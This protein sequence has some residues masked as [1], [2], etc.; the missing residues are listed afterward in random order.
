[1]KIEPTA[2]VI[3]GR[4]RTLVHLREWD[5]AL[6]FVEKLSSDAWLTPERLELVVQVLCEHERY[7]DALQAVRDAAAAGIPESR[8]EFLTAVILIRDRSRGHAVQAHDHMLRAVAAAPSNVSYW[9]A[10][11][12]LELNYYPELWTRDVC[13]TANRVRW[14][15]RTMMR[16]SCRHG[17]RWCWPKSYSYRGVWPTPMHTSGKR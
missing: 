15:L 12:H 16:N 4:L 14:L 8:L 9:I 13:R 3:D 6:A 5:Q 1:M 17:P 10:L 7:E 2:A 11:L